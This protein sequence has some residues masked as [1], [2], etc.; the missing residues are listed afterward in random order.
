[1]EI[2]KSILNDTYIIE[3][4]YI[5]FGIILSIVGFIFTRLFTRSLV[6]KLVSKSKTKWDDLLLDSK[7]FD[8][9]SY[10]VP[11]MIFNPFL[12]FIPGSLIIYQRI[13]ISLSILIIIGT[14]IL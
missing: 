11:L 10:L 3:Y 14:V 12:E 6:R 2:V 1:M 5:I 7:V 13:I 8:R 4:I 9:I